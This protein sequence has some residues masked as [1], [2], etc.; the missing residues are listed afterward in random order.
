MFKFVT[1]VCIDIKFELEEHTLKNVTH[2]FTAISHGDVFF[3][4]FVCLIIEM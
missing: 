4:C 3:F 1:K 2:K